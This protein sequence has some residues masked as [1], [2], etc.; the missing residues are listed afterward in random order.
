MNHHKTL[1]YQVLVGFSKDIPNYSSTLAGFYPK[2]EEIL[3][4]KISNVTGQREKLHKKI[5]MNLSKIAKI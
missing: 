5:K 4:I 3:S 2:H 1:N